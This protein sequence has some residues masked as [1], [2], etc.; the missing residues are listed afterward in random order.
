MVL[1]R[2]ADPPGAD[3]GR[4]PPTRVGVVASK[5][6]GGAVQRNRAK[7][8]LREL[9]RH[10]LDDLPAGLVVVVIA[11]AP[12]LR[13]AFVDLHRDLDRVA[14]DLSRIARRPPP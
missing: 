6:L 13:R 10:R 8:L 9:L 1:A 4:Q 2:G 12:L 5:R 3:V 14:R 11:Q 7:R